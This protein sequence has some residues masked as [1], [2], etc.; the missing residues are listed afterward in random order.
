MRKIPILDDD[1]VKMFPSDMIGWNNRGEK[2]LEWVKN[3]LEKQYQNSTSD[4]A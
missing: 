2:G 1:P 4:K 3:S